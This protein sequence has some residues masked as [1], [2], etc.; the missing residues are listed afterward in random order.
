MIIWMPLVGGCLQYVKEPTYEV[1]KNDV[2]AACTNHHC[3]EEV[4][5]YVQ[6]KFPWLYP[7]FHPWFIALWVSLQLQNASTVKMNTDW[8]FLRIFIFTDLKR[9]LNWLK[10]KVKKIEEKLNETG[11]HWLKV[12]FIQISYKKCFIRLVIGRVR[13]W[14]WEVSSR[15]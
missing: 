6:Q 13:Y 12:K 3:K 9:P 4:S 10:S 5:G 14:A 7:C 11:K 2:A 8:K 15:S 1:D